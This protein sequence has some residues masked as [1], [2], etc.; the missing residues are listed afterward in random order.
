MILGMDTW[1]F[2]A[3][4]LTIF[5]AIFCVVYGLYYEYLRKPKSKKTTEKK[6]AK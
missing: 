4:I 6:E 5:A 1:V 3:W 2:A